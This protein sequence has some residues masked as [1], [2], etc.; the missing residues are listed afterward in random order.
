MLLT[1]L[2]ENIGISNKSI[3]S[4]IPRKSYKLHGAGIQA[5]A[6]SHPRKPNSIVKIASISGENDPIYQFTK[7]CMEHTDNPFLPKI[8]TARLYNAKP[9]GY[10]T[11]SEE[12]KTQLTH[13][14]FISMEK[15]QFLTKQ[16]DPNIV[17]QLFKEIGISLSGNNV[18]SWD[19]LLKRIFFTKEGRVQI[20]QQTNN[21]Q[22]KEAL[23][24]LE[25]LFQKFRP[26]MRMG[27]LMLRTTVNP[28]QIVILD[29]ITH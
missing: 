3:S 27:N 29:P 22:L 18:A 5:T 2:I 4:N 15:L 17:E 1:E 28:P 20:L 10:D 24:L 6:Y 25:P 8:Y 23:T 16:I 21:S 7:L 9:T 19:I 14:L 11:D 13:K 12:N 26:D